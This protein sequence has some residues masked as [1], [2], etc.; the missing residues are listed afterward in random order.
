MLVWRFTISSGFYA[1]SLQKESWMINWSRKT[2]PKEIS[3]LTLTPVVAQGTSSQPQRTGRDLSGKAPQ[4]LPVQSSLV[5][6]HPSDSKAASEVFLCLWR[7]QGP[8]FL[9]TPCIPTAAA[10]I[11]HLRIVHL[12]GLSPRTEIHIFLI[13]C[14]PQAWAYHLDLFRLQSLLRALCTTCFLHFHWGFCYLLVCCCAVLKPNLKVDWRPVRRLAVLSAFP[15]SPHHWRNW[16]RPID[17]N[18]YLAKIDLNN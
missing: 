8:A 7:K 13:K 14:I 2:A 4:L 1:N 5:D 15:L 3:L 16:Q 17:Y 10:I 11:G 18:K 12:P 9:K 6:S